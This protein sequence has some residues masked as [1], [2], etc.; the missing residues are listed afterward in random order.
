[1]TN[2]IVINIC[3][4]GFSL[5]QKALEWLY[6]KG[7][8]YVKINPEYDSSKETTLYSNPKYYCASCEVPR[9]HPLL[10]ECVETLGE[11]ANGVFSELAIC[12]IESN[13]YRIEDYDGQETIIVPDDDKFT[14][15]DVRE[16]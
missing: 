11:E 6:E 16:Y 15:I 9:H 1:M 2:K 3:Y 14:Y 4:G 12:E 8:K 13:L 10:I 7:F 5:S